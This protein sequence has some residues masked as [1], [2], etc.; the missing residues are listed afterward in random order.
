MKL[1][2]FDTTLETCSVAL[3]DDDRLVAGRAERLV[4]GHAEA[5]LP[6]IEAVMNEAGLGYAELDALGVTVGPGTF[7]GQRIG[8]A[9]ARGIGLARKLPVQGVTTLSAIAYGVD[10]DGLVED[11]EDILVALDARRGDVY[12]QL[13]S[14]PLAWPQNRTSAA[15]IPLAGI[16][17]EAPQR[18]CVVVGTAV[19]LVETALA[20]GRPA[21]RYL[22]APAEAE[23]RHVA[24]LARREIEAHGL[25]RQP[26]SPLYLRAPD[27]KLPGGR[28]P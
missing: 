27:A 1:L 26:P 28:T 21:P 6:M 9:A 17:L 25:P 12:L 2:G 18:P 19:P 5:L 15:A 10:S 7:T 22:S 13:F 3:L 4:R 11:D 14:R 8:L 16:A 20:G 23:A 24:A